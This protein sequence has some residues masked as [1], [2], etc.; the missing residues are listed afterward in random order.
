MVFPFTV[1][2]QNLAENSEVRGRIVSAKGSNLEFVTVNILRESDTIP[3]RTVVSDTAGV[4]V[5]K[6]VPQGSYSLTATLVGFKKHQEAAFKVTPGGPLNLGNIVLAETAGTLNQVVVTAKRPLIERKLDRTILN[7]ENSILA[8]G[9]SA[10]EVLQMAPGVS[11]VG[12]ASIELFGKGN[13]LIMIDGKPTY[14]SIDQLTTMLKGMPSDQISKIEVISQPSAR[15]DAAGVSGIINIVTKR[16]Q[17]QGWTGSVSGGA[18]YARRGKYRG[19]LNLAYKGEDFAFTVDYSNTYNNSIRYLDIN[20]I[21]NDNG[22]TTYFDRSGSFNDKMRGNNFKT[23]F[24]YYIN[25]NNSLGVQLMGYNNQQSTL[26]DNYTGIHSYNAPVDSFLT[27]KATEQAKFQSI[28]GNIN[29]YSK[30][31]KKNRELNFDADYARFR[32]NNNRNFICI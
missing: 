30:L 6:E 17:T 24:T 9:S 8:T 12:D 4:F 32:N 10:F 29:Y 25:K 7:V 20:R 16:K 27:S 28:G 1:T 15:Y 5:F 23:T 22:T 2:A 31:D 26:V 21:V 18:G 13:P 14:L 3:L 11:I 19:S